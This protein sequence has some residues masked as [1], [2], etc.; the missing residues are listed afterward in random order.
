MQKSSY[1]LLSA[2][3]IASIF[4][5]C[6]NKQS[7]KNSSPQ[8]IEAKAQ[9]N[10]ESAPIKTDGKGIA[11]IS[12][13]DYVMKLHN[14]FAYQPTDETILAGMKPKEGFRFIY[15]DVSLKNTS[16]EKLDGGSLFI[17]LKINGEDG[18]EYKKPAAA[19]AS[20]LTEN[21][22]K[23][24][25]EEYDELWENFQP[26][27]F[28]RELIYAVEVPV[29]ITNFSLSMPVDRQRKEWKTLKFSV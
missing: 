27:E 3:F 19:L 15:L 22:G 9:K 11:E 29:H 26:G 23:S 17:A 28:H 18:Q 13:E 20:Y 24:N 12:T 10:T 25:K 1:I 5:A 4:I 6:E 16:S 7:A 21:P 14:V 2:V 8:K